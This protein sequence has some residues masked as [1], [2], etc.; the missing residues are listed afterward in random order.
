M[1]RPELAARWGLGPH[2]VVAAG[3]GDAAAGAI[4]I[5]AISDGDAFL[6]IGTSGQL[7]VTTATY[8]PAPAT[9]VH[10]FAHALP[11]RWFQMGAML[12]GA[13]CLAFAAGMMGGEIGALL[14]EAERGFTGPATPLFLPYL[15]GERTPHDDP[16]A[17]GVL[18]GLSGGTGRGEIMQAVLEGV[19]F[20][21]VDARD[22]LAASGTT[23][24][25]A[26]VIGG[27][28]RSTFWM[29]IMAAALGIPL[30]RYDGAAKGPA[31]GA[32]RLARLAFSREDPA[33]VCTTPPLLDV[34]EP[35]AALHAAYIPRIE[36][37]RRL[38]RTLRPEFGNG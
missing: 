15:S 23:V 6:S 10:A 37:F 32:A 28:A 25:Q 11:G 13:S 8:R 4:G 19:A 9:A 20:S 34:T 38:Y 36:R 16:H 31:Y 29:R 2:V 33:Q 30:R 12:N 35:D 7:F 26:A 17:R 27:G 22:A 5:G 24:T 3:A 21:F 14:D 18:F 1:L